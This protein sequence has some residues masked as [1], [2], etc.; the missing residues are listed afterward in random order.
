VAALRRSLVAS[1]DATHFA[2]RRDK[3]AR[4]A[5]LLITLMHDN[6]DINVAGLY[7]VLKI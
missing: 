2:R 3:E 1:T 7:L 6:G 5:C 4:R